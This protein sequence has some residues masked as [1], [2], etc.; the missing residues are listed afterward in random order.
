MANSVLAP[1]GSFECV[2]TDGADVYRAAEEALKEYNK[3]KHN[4]YELEAVTK[5]EKQLVAGYNYRLTFKA[6]E[7]FN[8]LHIVVKCNALVYE[9]LK[10]KLTVENVDCKSIFGP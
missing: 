5:A 10:N 6:Q 7:H 9:S 3:R 4:K 1:L 8:S 2:E